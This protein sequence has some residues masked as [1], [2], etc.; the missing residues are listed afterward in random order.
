MTAIDWDRLAKRLSDV[1][2]KMA[3]EEN[4]RGAD[5]HAE[6]LRRTFGFTPAGEPDGVKRVLPYDQVNVPGLMTDAEAKHI[7]DAHTVIDRI[8]REKAEQEVKEMRE[9]V[10]RVYRESA[11]DLSD[12]IR[13]RC[14][15]RTV[16]SRYRREGA[17]W[18][19]DLIDPR[20]PKDRYGNFVPSTQEA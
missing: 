19:A 14:N 18:A 20:V 10:R 2:R 8:N 16:P 3:H 7:R 6:A 5:F 13:N 15:E 11:A 17:Q 1:Q 4:Y 12:L 9:E